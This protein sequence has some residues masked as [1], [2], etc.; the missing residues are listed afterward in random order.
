MHPFSLTS[1]PIQLRPSR[2]SLGDV[3]SSLLCPF[4]AP[5]CEVNCEPKTKY[6]NEWTSDKIT[7][8]PHLKNG[9]LDAHTSHCGRA[10]MKSA[11]Q[12]K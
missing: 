2:G 1:N 5:Y 11:R 8:K 7:E 3:Q 9:R 6:I 4:I 12:V 10:I